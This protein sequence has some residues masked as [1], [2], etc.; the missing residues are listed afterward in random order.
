MPAYFNN[1]IHLTDAKGEV[2]CTASAP[3]KGALDAEPLGP[4]HSWM[5]GNQTFDRPAAHMCK[6]CQEAAVDF[7]AKKS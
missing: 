5:V 4:K 1:T 3:P 7:W 2:R 6:A